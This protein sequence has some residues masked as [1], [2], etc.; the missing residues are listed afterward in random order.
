MVDEMVD[1]MWLLVVV[2]LFLVVGFHNLNIHNNGP[3]HH[4]R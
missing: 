3:I 2:R 4:S 1:E